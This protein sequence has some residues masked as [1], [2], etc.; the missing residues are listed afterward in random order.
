MN[1][2]VILSVRDLHVKFSLRGQQ[3]HALRGISLDIYKGES[4]A[5]VGESGSGKSVFVKN[6]N[7]LLDKNGWIDSGHIYY[8]PKGAEEACCTARSEEE[9]LAGQHT[10]DLAALKTDAE[11]GNIRGKEIA[12]VMQDPMTS[13]NPLKTVG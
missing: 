3:L 2:E 8:L 13:L 9:M 10:W 4:L 11:W 7:G 5:I 6:F 1:N 12:M